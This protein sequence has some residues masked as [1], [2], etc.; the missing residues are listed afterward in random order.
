M[1]VI[2]LRL[3]GGFEARMRGDASLLTLPTRK[4]EAVLAYLITQR[5]RLV[6]RDVLTSLLWAD[7]PRS[8]G[9]HSLRQTLS[10]VRRMLEACDGD[11]TL[12]TVADGIGI[13]GDCLWADSTEFE[14]LATESGSGALAQACEL[15]RAPF[16]DGFTVPE[17]P[18]DHWMRSERTR[19][20]QLAIGMFTRRLQVLEPQS[21]VGAAIHVA[22]RLLELDPLQER[23]HRTLMR[24]YSRIGQF[25]SAI[26]QYEQ[27]SQRLKQALGVEP[28][29]ETTSLY[30]GIGH[31]YPAGS[32]SEQ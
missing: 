12:V 9:R 28:S 15:Y 13:H 22:M 32:M 24:L 1:T 3:F 10:R 19:L 8:Q 14:R 6:R 11:D 30:R 16:L 26:K 27:C 29:P 7:V 31:G 18:F 25:G 5:P 23:V 2:E 17:P 20:H 4:S 21:D